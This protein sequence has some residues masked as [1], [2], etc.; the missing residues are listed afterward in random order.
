MHVASARWNSWKTN[1]LGFESPDIQAC[2]LIL[3]GY[4][5]ERGYQDNPKTVTEFEEANDIGI[6]YIESEV[7]NIDI[8]MYEEK[9]SRLYWIR[10]PHKNGCIWERR[11]RNSCFLGL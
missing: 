7:T 2:D 11:G 5:K 4:L 6:G 3:W 8:D 1:F 10:S 9:G